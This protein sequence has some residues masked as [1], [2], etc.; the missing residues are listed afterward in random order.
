MNMTPDL[1]FL[2]INNPFTNK[3]ISG[4]LD[5]HIRMSLGTKVFFVE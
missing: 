4:Y 5:K 1:P 2:N 3:R